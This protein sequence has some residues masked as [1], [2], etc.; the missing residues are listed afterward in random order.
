MAFSDS[1]LG[2]VRELVRAKWLARLIAA[3]PD[4]KALFEALPMERYH[5]ACGLI[6]HTTIWNKDSRLFSPAEVAQ[7]KKMSL[8]DSLEDALGPFEIADIE[9]LGYPEIY[10]RLVRPGAGQDVAGAHTDTW[11]Y[12]YT[13]NLTLAEQQGLVK[14]WVA[15]HVEPG[16][17]GLAVLPDSHLKAWPHHAEVRHGRP[18]PVL[19]VDQNSLPFINVDTQPGEAIIFNIGLLHAGIGHESGN[20]RISMEFSVRL[21]Q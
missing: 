1:E 4:K 2:A 3:R 8:F 17:S 6:D 20:S 19:D 21:R 11:F 10:W 18:K 12:T 7:L 14:V 15:I 13:N 16:H 5:E 9:G